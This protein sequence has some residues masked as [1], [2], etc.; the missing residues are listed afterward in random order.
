VAILGLGSAASSAKTTEATRKLRPVTATGFGVSVPSD[1]I[2][3]QRA[4]AQDAELA[5]LAALGSSWIRLDLFWSDVEPRQRGARRW[6]RFDATIKRAHRH[7]M[8]ILLVVQA[9][10]RWAAVRSD[11]TAPPTRV[12]DYAAFLGRAVRRYK[13]VVNTWEIWNEPNL[14][15][16]WTGTQRQYARLL[17][18]ANTAIKRA[19]PTAT[20]LSGGLAPQEP[21]TGPRG[22]ASW[23]ESFYNYGAGRSFDVLALHLYPRGTQSVVSDP[24]T[25]WSQTEP[26][27]SN[28]RSIMA[29]NGDGKKRIWATEW[30]YS[31]RNFEES[32]IQTRIL[33]DVGIWTSAVGTGVL[34]WY[35]NR[36]ESGYGLSLE[37]YPLVHRPRWDSYRQAI[38]GSIWKPRGC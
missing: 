13:G 22:V 38:C 26:S 21:S 37:S 35:S 9:T 14:P 1:R 7:G 34:F 25:P 2:V 18:A 12:A 10:P 32:A 19:D 31:S 23:L 11:P 20:V 29:A 3:Y 5:D 24:A 30:G 16:F 33:S 6:A 28:V 15:D 36:D 17:I 4:A 8:K 27:R